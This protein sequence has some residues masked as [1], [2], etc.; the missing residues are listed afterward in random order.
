MR[1]LL[2]VLLLTLLYWH[3]VIYTLE[4]ASNYAAHMA[5]ALLAKRLNDMSHQ[6]YELH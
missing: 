4:L 6:R 3:W 1:R 5:L 2:C